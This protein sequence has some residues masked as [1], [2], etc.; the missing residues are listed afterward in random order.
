MVLTRIIVISICVVWLSCTPEKVVRQL[1]SVERDIVLKRVLPKIFNEIVPS[2]FHGNY[3]FYSS[4]SF[5]HRKLIENLLEDMELSKSNAVLIEH[6]YSNLK[7][8]E[9]TSLDFVDC[10]RGTIV[11]DKR[12]GDELLESSWEMVKAVFLISEISF[13]N[14]VGVF[15]IH[16]GGEI[17]IGSYIV[18]LLER[19]G[20]LEFDRI[21]QV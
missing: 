18:F 5:G 20:V 14:G 19:N 13:Y 7:F 17:G 6:L 4:E 3:I 2:K 9:T 11:F 10:L 1:D 8:I 21:L 12:H 16:M 15:Y